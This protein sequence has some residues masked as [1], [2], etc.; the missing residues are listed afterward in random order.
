MTYL[1]FHLVFIIPIIFVVH[2]LERRE[3]TESLPGHVSGIASLVL[4]AFVYTTPWDNYLVAS[5]IWSYSDGRIIEELVIGY[6]PIEEYLFFVLQPIMTG[7]FFLLFAARL[8]VNRRAL[9][10]PLKRGKPALV[11]LLT[12]L[13]I[14]LLGLACITI[15][16]DRYRYLGLILIWASPVLGFQW[17]YGGGLL[18]RFRKLVITSVALPSLYLWVVDSIAIT[19]GIWN[20][21]PDTSTGWMIFNLPMEEAIF[22]LVTNMMVVQGLLLY[23]QAFVRLQARKKNSE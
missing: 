23:Y 9:N 11:G 14:S 20:I 12:F 21:V 22:F 17:A 1:T 3:R 16:A 8:G 2:F 15:L 7:G 4:I 13:A 5:N 6:V 10:H 18:W 19:W